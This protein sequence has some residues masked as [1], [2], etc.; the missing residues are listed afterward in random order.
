MTVTGGVTTGV[1]ATGACA[2]GTVGA[3]R[4][5]GGSDS[6]GSGTAA[7]A[8]NNTHGGKTWTRRQDARS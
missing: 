6:A 1:E 5:V 3:A 8:G 2:V 4:M 7:A